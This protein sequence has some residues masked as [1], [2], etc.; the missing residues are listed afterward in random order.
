MI[1]NGCRTSQLVVHVKKAA[2]HISKRITNLQ[3]K[4]GEVCGWSGTSGGTEKGLKTTC[5]R[6]LVRIRV[7]LFY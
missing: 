1:I 3:L 2:S 5:F 4:R 6:M 7:V